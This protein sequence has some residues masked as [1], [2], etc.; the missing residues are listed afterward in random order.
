MPSIEEPTRS[1]TFPPS[2]C[3]ILFNNTAPPPPPPDDLISQYFPNTTFLFPGMVTQKRASFHQPLFF[4]NFF[5][6]RSNRV[7]KHCQGW[8]M[9]KSKTRRDAEI[10]V[11]NPSPRLFGEKFRDSKKVK[12]NHEKTRL[13]DLSKTFP[14]FQDPAKILR[15]SRFSRYHSPS[16]LSIAHFKYGCYSV[17]LKCEQISAI[18]LTP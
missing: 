14:R 5:S 16:L 7:V 17:I 6:E 11:R 13:R 1:S 8:R 12:T 9:V 15:D 18:L 10:L 2:P 4:L 3:V